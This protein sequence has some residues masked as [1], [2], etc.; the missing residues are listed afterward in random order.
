MSKSSELFQMMRE[1]SG[2]DSERIDMMEKRY[3]EE[4]EYKEWYYS[5]AG[6]KN[7]DDVRNSLN[8]VFMTFHPIHLIQDEIKK[9]I[10][11]GK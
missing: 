2:L 7:R 6:K 10:E 1:E 9:N 8:N 5:E 4:M 3:Q 11:N